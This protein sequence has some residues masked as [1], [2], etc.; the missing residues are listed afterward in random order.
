MQAPAGRHPASPADPA[1]GRRALARYLPACVLADCAGASPRQRRFRGAVLVADIA[2]FSRLTERFAAQGPEGAER[3]AAVLDAWFGRMTEAALDHGGDVVDF[4]GDALV[5][6]WT[7]EDLQQALLGAA[8]AAWALRAAGDEVATATGLA[9]KQRI[10][11]GA[12]ELALFGVGLGQQW[13]GLVAGAPVAGAAALYRHGQPGDIL[14]CADSWP[15]L[16]PLARGQKLDTGADMLLQALEPMPPPAAAEPPEA[17]PGMEQYLPPAL[18]GRSR[19]DA[20]PWPGEFRMLST[21]MIGFPGLDPAAP[22]A[23][24]RLQTAVSTTQRELQR[25]GG[26]IERLSMDDKGI[27]I[28]TAWGLPQASFDDDAARALRAAGDSEAALRQQGIACALGL[29]SGRVFCGDSGGH[30]RRHLSLAGASVNRAARLMQLG[31]GLRCDAA[32]AHAASRDW[33]F[34]PESSAA[35][36]ALRPQRRQAPVL[37]PREAALIGREAE[38]HRVG[39]A[40]QAAGSGHG[41]LLLVIGEAGIG[42]SRLLA[43]STARA[44]AQGLQV[45]STGGM[46]V[47]ANTPYFPWRR[48]LEQVLLRDGAPGPAALLQELQARLQDEP[49]LLPWLPLVNDILPLQIPDNEL[50]PQITGAARARNLQELLSRLLDGPAPGALLLLDDLHWW[51]E[52]S[53]AML[54][55]ILQRLP[56]LP[57]IAASRPASDIAAA[58]GDGLQRLLL[59]EQSGELRLEALQRD[60]A[61]QLAARTLGLQDAGA[62]ALPHALVELLY[63][64]TAGNPF[65]CEELTLALRDSGVLRVDGNRVLLDSPA[66][67]A[68]LAEAPTTLRGTIVSRYDRLHPS[69]QAALKLAS[70]IGREVSPQTLAALLGEHD[71]DAALQQLR[72]TGL[73]R[74]DDGAQTAAYHFKHALLR[75]VV[76]DLL[77]FAQRRKLHRDVAR[78]I[79]TQGEALARATELAMHWESAGDIA[80]ALHYLEHAARNALA[81]DA[82]REAI[83][84]VQRAYALAARLS[85]TPE[86]A[87]LGEWEAILGDA[88][89]ELFEYGP[90]VHHYHRALQLMG[91]P[92]RI[93]GLRRGW[94]LLKE[95]AIQAWHRQRLPRREADARRL[96]QLSRAAH[97]HQRLVETAF[98]DNR[99][100]ELLYQTLAS[101]N[102]AEK[103]DFT[104][105]RVSSYAGLAMAC[106][107]MR[108]T[109]LADDYSQRSLLAS[110]AGASTDVAYS[111]LGRMVYRASSGHWQQVHESYDAG[112]PLYRSLGITGRWQQIRVTDLVAWFAQGRYDES[113]AGVREV[114]EAPGAVIPAQIQAWCWSYDTLLS[115][116][117]GDGPARLPALVQGYTAL[118]LQEVSLADRM[119]CV[120][121]MAQAQWRLGETEAALAH[122]DEAL[123]LA[124]RA[125]PSTFYL[126]P[127]LAAVAA[128]LC[129]A[130]ERETDPARH[131]AL[132]ERSGRMARVLR[133]MA[134]LVPT[135]GPR[136][137][138][139]RA[140]QS[141]L[142]GK[143]GP[144][145][146]LWRRALAQAEALDMPY[147][148][149]QALE[150]MGRWLDPQTALAVQRRA[151]AAA[152]Y[153][154]IGALPPP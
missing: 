152:I 137:A 107:A 130:C 22:G 139:A 55:A 123:V 105:V 79:E 40:L 8:Q 21:L 100:A 41:G 93:G 44:A 89:Q 28:L 117:R 88:H 65:F 142:R 138:L 141:W 7:G 18:V 94:L 30:R 34:E 53:L 91:R 153:A 42:K 31:P 39:Q 24:A 121:A 26:R 84:H 62:S 90:S 35:D 98:F 106:M 13:H 20:A 95:A 36:A 109:R 110:R 52:A 83:R 10:A 14:V 129:A 144:A 57:V 126:A 119:L 74:Q 75:D 150:A 69:A 32:T 135:A 12:G 77:P 70:V 134:W 140:R 122:A 64:R 81:R 47:E 38:Q 96:Q 50:T 86:S 4:V 29:S 103:T 43:D 27:S 97:I 125:P 25:S 114:L 118:P 19:A 33:S 136:A 92:G 76:Y 45:I 15:L 73:L 133:Q 58:A 108:Q 67:D 116:L 16:A 113:A 146:R 1:E 11:I 37:R 48:V 72:D 9:L 23:L 149:A 115:A 131:A 127:G 63:Q 68:A 78:H 87:R 151:T 102:L 128:V 145:E 120:S 154:R 56:L 99:P 6:S 60:A 54:E 59:R 124:R 80:Q 143:R 101:V 148:Q 66:D 61:A 71:V 104:Y 85:G 112:T 51:D 2:G 17:G 82:N 49:R 111:H 132:L 46:A 3:L 5:V 147:E